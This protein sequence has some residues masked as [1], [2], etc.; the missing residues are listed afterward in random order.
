MNPRNLFTDFSPLSGLRSIVA[1]LA[2]LSVLLSGCVSTKYK[3]A[4]ENTPPPMLLNL[5]ATQP[6]LEVALNMVIIYQGPGSWKRAAFWDEYVVTLH[7]Q[8]DQPLTIAS[9]ALADPLGVTHAPGVDPWALE[10]ESKTLERKFLDAGVG[11]VRYAGGG[12]VIVGAGAGG[13]AAAGIFSASAGVV[14]GATV[15]ALPMY[16]LT[17]WATNSDNKAGIVA[18]FSRRRL[19]L[20]LT[21]A[22]GETRIGSLF[23][24]MVP[25]PRTLSLQW[26]SGTSAGDLTLPL[27]S[28][29]GL[30]VK[31]PT[32]AS[33][34]K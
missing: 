10:K 11:F 27:E 32:P 6:P 34:G 33:A 19:A 2:A 3:M 23:F 4:R 13:V 12:V 15:I 16:Y 20:P 29:H 24:P 22:P 31:A 25:S 8:G 26:S 14:A 7:N 18:E 21:L 9:A 1:T 17:V 30:H 5:A 28:V